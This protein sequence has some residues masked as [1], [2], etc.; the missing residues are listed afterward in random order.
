MCLRAPEIRTFPTFDRL[1]RKEVRPR[2][3][4]AWFYKYRVHGMEKRLALGPW[5]EVSLA[6]ARDLRDQA[7]RAVR[8]G[9]DP[10]Q[11]RKKEKITAQ[12]SD[13]NSF[14]SVAEDF[15]EVKFVG[16]RKADT[17]HRVPITLARRG[18]DGCAPEGMLSSA[19]KSNGSPR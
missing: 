17:Q 7:R 5:P 1:Y 16:N 13:G 19:G 11:E 8:S 15:I 6:E 10:L 3:G 12:L 14:Q 2:G 18:C 9:K 4:K